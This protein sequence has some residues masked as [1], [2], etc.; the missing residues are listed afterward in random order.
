MSD[1]PIKDLVEDLESGLSSPV[2]R[3][4]HAAVL[5]NDRKNGIK[6]IGEEIRDKDDCARLFD[7]F[8]F[9]WSARAMKLTPIH[10]DEWK[11]KVIPYERLD[12]AAPP[13]YL[14]RIGT[15]VFLS[16]ARRDR[17]SKS[18][19]PPVYFQDSEHNEFG[20]NKIDEIIEITFEK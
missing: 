13:K 17:Y 6:Y 4:I 15:T 11:E 7:Y 1:R 12:Q 10:K 14:V 20:F 8:R 18:K 16:Y 3:A 5:N 9:E 2:A 19:N